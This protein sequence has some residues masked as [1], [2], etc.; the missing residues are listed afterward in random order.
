MNFSWYIVYIFVSYNLFGERERE[1]KKKT[2][3]E[4]TNISGKIN[5]AYKILMNKSN[6][7]ILYSEDFY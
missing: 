5:N 2:W 4:S 6:I 3:Y 1:G 7:S